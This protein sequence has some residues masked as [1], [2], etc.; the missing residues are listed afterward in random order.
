MNGALHPPKLEVFDIEAMTN[1]DPKGF[2]RPVDEY[3]LVE[4]G[5]FM[6]RPVAGHPDLAYFQSWLLPG[7]GLRVNKWDRHPGVP[8]DLDFYIDVVDIETGPAWRTTDLYLDIVVRT[9]LDQR[10]LDADETLAALTAGLIDQD[11]AE[12]AFRRAFRAVDGIAAARWDV[13]AWLA[14]QGVAIT[15]RH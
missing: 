12:R 7:M 11:A 13:D 3:R 1:T 6:A 4:H 2:V 5:L 14:A 9:G 10:L 8:S 15:W